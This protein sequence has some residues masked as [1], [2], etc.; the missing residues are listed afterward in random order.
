MASGVNKPFAS[1]VLEAL[2]TPPTAL[3]QVQLDEQKTRNAANCITAFLCARLAQTG[4]APEPVERTTFRWNDGLINI[5]NAVKDHHWTNLRP[6]F[7]ERFRE[8]KNGGP[9]VYT[10][11]AWQ[12][13]D[14]GVHVWAIP[15][16]VVYKALPDHPVGK[17]KKKR[18]IRISHADP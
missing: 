6:S 8:I 7:A 12:P 10:I 14:T 18:T 4:H 15:E 1:L 3:P 16:E 17:M 11:T 9:A 5:R 2:S 13:L